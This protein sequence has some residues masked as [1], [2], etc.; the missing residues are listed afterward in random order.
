MIALVTAVLLT[1]GIS[2]LCS[3]MEA[4]ILSITTAEIEGFKKSHPRQGHLLETYKDGINETSSAILT[5]NT[6]ANTAGATVVG[7]LADNLM[8]GVIAVSAF[9]TIS[10]LIFSE[11]IPKSLGFAHRKSLQPILVYPIWFIRFM[12]KP[13]SLFF[14]GLL[15]LFMQQA[16]LT[17]AEQEEEI[18]LLAEKSVKSGAL[19][20]DERELIANAISLDDV[21]IEDIMTPRTV[22][23]SMQKNALVGEVCQ[24]FNNLPFARIPVFGEN[25]DDI[26]GIVR[27]RDLLQAYSENKN[28]VPVID[29]ASDAIYIPETAS[30]MNALQ[31][32]LKKHQQLAIVVDE[33]GSTAGVVSMEDIVEHLIGKEIY[34]DSDVAVDMRELAKKRAERRPAATERTSTGSLLE[35][36]SDE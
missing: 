12:M 28:E 2:A 3:L 5:L 32:F 23:T 10:I 11:V 35:E 1:L 34:E 19:S 33:Y 9:M 13:F 20:A 29:L 16:V 14:R 22:M 31:L 24:S 6:I 8:F 17:E 30:A 27:R 18:M 7:A 15:G 4:F 36:S 21:R 25:I 26:V